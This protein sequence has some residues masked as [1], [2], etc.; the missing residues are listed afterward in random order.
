M[1]HELFELFEVATEQLENDPAI[2][3][4]LESG[5][6]TPKSVSINYR[7]EKSI[8]CIG[9]TS[10]MTEEKYH[11]VRVVIEGPSG[12]A[13]LEEIQD[14][15]NDAAAQLEGVICQDVVLLHNR[16]DVIFLTLK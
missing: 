2:V 15:L 4:F 6:Y 5:L 12:L 10:D 3:N 14:A 1:K 11:L 8:V 9:Y 7:G 13:P 16:I